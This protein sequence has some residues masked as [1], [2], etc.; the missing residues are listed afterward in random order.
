M[1]KLPNAH[2]FV[3]LSDY[4]RPIALIIAHK[5]KDTLITPIQ[6]TIWFV[7]SG[8]I[9]IYCILFDHLFLAAFF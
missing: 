8:L 2:K 9:A 4:G 3:D 1:S 5:L 6:V 7:I